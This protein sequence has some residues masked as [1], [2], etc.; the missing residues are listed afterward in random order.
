[1]QQDTGNAKQE[2]ML[3]ER[4]TKHNHT[5]RLKFIKNK[6]EEKQFTII[7]DASRQTRFIC[8][9]VERR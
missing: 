1:M 2:G 6:P 8:G 9:N 3:I 4:A 7:N 5:C